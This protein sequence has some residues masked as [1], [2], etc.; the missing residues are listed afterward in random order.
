MTFTHIELFRLKQAQEILNRAL[1]QTVID[2]GMESD[3]VSALKSL[4]TLIDDVK[5]KQDTIRKG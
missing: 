2:S 4:Q 3:L 1:K 5:V